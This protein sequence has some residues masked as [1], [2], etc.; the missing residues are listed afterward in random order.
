MYHTLNSC[1]GYTN[2]FF[3]YRQ[4]GIPDPSWS[5]LNHFIE[6]LDTQLR[7]SEHSIFCN[8]DIIGDVMSGFKSFVVKFMVRMSMVLCI[9]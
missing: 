1:T 6:F 3:E 7:S 4:C 9:K 5:E 2:C 8:E